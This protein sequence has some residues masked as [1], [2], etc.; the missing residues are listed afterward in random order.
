MRQP[1][2]P[3]PPPPA[4]NLNVPEVSMVPTLPTVQATPE[5]FPTLQA[6]L[7]LPEKRT[8]ARLQQRRVKRWIPFTVSFFELYDC[9]TKRTRF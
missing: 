2:L 7:M 5:E 6:S 8:T 9:P 4:A 3:T 1:L